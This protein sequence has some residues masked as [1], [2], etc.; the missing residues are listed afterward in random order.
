MNRHTKNDYV[1]DKG[2]PSPQKMGLSLCEVTESYYLAT[3]GK[4]NVTYM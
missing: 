4:K 1:N 3:V 2:Q